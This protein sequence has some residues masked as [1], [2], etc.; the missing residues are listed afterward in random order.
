MTTWAQ[1]L[2]SAERPRGLLPGERRDDVREGQGVRRRKRGENW[3]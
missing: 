1:R 3:K 2:L